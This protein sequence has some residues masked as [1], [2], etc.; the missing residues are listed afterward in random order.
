[1]AERNFDNINEFADAFRGNWKKFKNFSWSDKPEITTGGS[2]N[3]GIMHTVSRDSGILEESNAEAI[4]KIMK[5]FIDEE[6]D[7]T[8]E[9]FNH[10]AHGWVDG[11][12]IKVN[13]TVMRKGKHGMYTKAFV[14]LW[15]KIVEPLQDY[16][17]LDEE[18][19]SKREYEAALEY[20]VQNK[21]LGVSKEA[22]R[23][24]KGKGQT[25]RGWVADV[26]DWLF[27]NEKL[28]TSDDGPYADD[29]D[30]AKAMIDLRVVDFSDVL[31][32][33]EFGD[34]EYFKEA[35][36][37]ALET[38]LRAIKEDAADAMEPKAK[39]R[40]GWAKKILEKMW[41]M[42]LPL[43]LDAGGFLKKADILKAAKA[44]GF[45]YTDAPG[46]TTLFKNPRG[47]PS[48]RTR[49]G[50]T[51]TPIEFS[52]KHD[53][54]SEQMIR[55]TMAKHGVVIVKIDDIPREPSK[56]VPKE[57]RRLVRKFRGGPDQQNLSWHVKALV[58]NEPNDELVYDIQDVIQ[59]AFGLQYFAVKHGAYFGPTIPQKAWDVFVKGE[60]INT[61]FYDSDVSAEEVERTLISHDGYDQRIVVRP[62]KG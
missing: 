15:E 62:S 23:E 32:K 19:Y 3:W 28:I 18:D 61:V 47:K 57:L 50:T 52:T 13:A 22:Q 4:Q 59:E 29:K 9:H 43:K 14:T 2:G 35:F 10:W 45:T 26:Y 38:F 40:K 11:I 24:L 1:M 27:D 48:A 42:R 6:E 58:P 17:I 49:S 31:D 60:L 30:I 44:L 12:A 46:Q 7:A 33:D 55:D 41:I 37:A 20:I 25:G 36:G 51:Y 54:V 21:P 34:S 5:P 8:E 39:R 16:P 53:Y 56:H